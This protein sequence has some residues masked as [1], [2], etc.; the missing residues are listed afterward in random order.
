M[1]PVEAMQQS[2]GF[3]TSATVRELGKSA[4][5]QGT[6]DRDYYQDNLFAVLG[7]PMPPG[8]GAAVK[9]RQADFLAGRVMARLALAWLNL[10]EIEI[11]VGESRQPMWPPGLHGSISHSGARCV[12]LVVP[13]TDAL[14]G[15]DLETIATGPALEAIIE[16][17]LTSAEQALPGLD[18][19]LATLLFSAKETIFKAHF[20][21]VGHYFG[22]DAAEL[23]AMDDKCLTFR[24]TQELGPALSRGHEI[25]VRY[26]AQEDHVMTWTRIS[27]A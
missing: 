21:V 13:D 10:P 14:V 25:A 16:R 22:F 23:V 27:K 15:I 20:S 17:C 26:A 6:F 9:K 3:L 18:P 4:L 2:F 19:S 5:A 24:L 11:G 1:K 7:I 8:V 12:A